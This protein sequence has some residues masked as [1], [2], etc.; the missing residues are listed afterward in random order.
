MRRTIVTLLLAFSTLFMTQCRKNIES[1]IH[2]AKIKVSASVATN[3]AKT[4]I[5]DAGGVAWK[6]GD[7]IHVVGETAGYLGTIV[8]KTDGNPVLFEGEINAIT[9]SQNFHYYYVGAKNFNIVG[10]SYSFEISSQTGSL[11]DIAANQHLMHGVSSVDIEPNT[12][13]LGSFAM[14]N[15]MSVAKMR[16]TRNDGKPLQSEIACKGAVTSVKL[17]VKNGT[18]DETT[19]SV[20]T[21]AMTNVV[22]VENTDYSDYYYIALI[23]GTQTLSFVQDDVEVE[24]SEKEVGPN[25]FYSITGVVTLH[26]FLPLDEIIPGKFSVSANEQIYFARGNIYYDGTDKK[27]K[28]ENMQCDF[29]TYSNKV[30][31]IDS[32]WKDN[33]TPAND[34]GTFGWSTANT[35][36]G[37]STSEIDGAYSGDFVDW[38]GNFGEL[39]FTLSKGQWDYLLETRASA[40]ELRKIKNIKIKDGSGKEKDL[41]GLILLPDGTK[42]PSTVFENINSHANLSKCNAVFLPAAGDRTGS[43][44]GNQNTKG[45]YWTSTTNSSSAT[46][47]YRISFAETGFDNGFGGRKYGRPV[48]LTC[49][50]DGYN[51]IDDFS[52]VIW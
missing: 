27:W 50:V 39:W 13:Y 16:F 28:F 37:M 2:G 47:A 6:A 25:M 26:S 36:Y 42:D 17:K 48:R 14:N 35:M 40:T 23:P 21:I 46:D 8:A 34:W 43:V 7:K 1:P 32:V 20:G 19:K 45:F 22:E 5:S 51:S 4:T 38:G 33:G 49:Y 29:R 10:D 44:P 11:S 30:A 18:F 41:L 31:V 9:V 12:T 15:M 52:P 24:F 3:G